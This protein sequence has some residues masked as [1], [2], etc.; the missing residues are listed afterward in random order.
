MPT[1]HTREGVER[2]VDLIR[3][4]AQAELLSAAAC[5]QHRPELLNAL[6]HV[7]ELRTQKACSSFLWDQYSRVQ[8][9]LGRAL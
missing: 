8:A 6:S 4:I 5:P 3:Q 1:F 2:D 7:V 9:A